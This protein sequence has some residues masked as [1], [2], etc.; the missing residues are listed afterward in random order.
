MINLTNIYLSRGRERNISSLTGYKVAV[1]NNFETITLD[2]SQDENFGIGSLTT[3]DAL[4]RASSQL[5]KLYVKLCGLPSSCE[6]GE[7]NMEPPS[8]QKIGCN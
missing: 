3:V 2:Q 5:Q 6:E 1:T 7:K 4:I 8:W